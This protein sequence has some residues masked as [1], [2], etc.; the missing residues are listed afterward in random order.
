MKENQENW[1]ME[2][3]RNVLR[4]VFSEIDQYDEVLIISSGAL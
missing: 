3:R 1:T 2:L 4:S